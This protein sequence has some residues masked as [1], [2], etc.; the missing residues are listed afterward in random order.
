VGATS[1]RYDDACPNLIVGS[2][3]QMVKSGFD[4]K[5]DLRTDQ[6]KACR[7]RLFCNTQPDSFWKAVMARDGDY[8]AQ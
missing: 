5:A 3:R 6:A 1:R 8:P 4:Q 2:A 7:M